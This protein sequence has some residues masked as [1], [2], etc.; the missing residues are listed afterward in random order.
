MEIEHFENQEHEWDS[1]LKVAE[2]VDQPVQVNPQAMERMLR[3]RQQLM[4]L[5]WY[6]EGIHRELLPRLL[7]WYD[8]N[9]IENEGMK[10]IKER[11]FDGMYEYAFRLMRIRTKS[12]LY[13]SKQL[14]K[15][16]LVH[17]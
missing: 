10:L 14:Y 7:E 8:K 15:K 5:E 9:D 3:N 1:N 12:I 13:K 4:P 6:V 2:G 16:L 17:L 11:D